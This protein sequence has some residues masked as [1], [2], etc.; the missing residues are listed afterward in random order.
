MQR[1]NAVVQAISLGKISEFN[2][3]VIFRW[4]IHKDHWLRKFRDD[5]VR[6]MTNMGGNVFSYP[7]SRA[8]KLIS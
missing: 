6:K 7:V 1:F 5:A 3:P 8:V 2:L 4:A